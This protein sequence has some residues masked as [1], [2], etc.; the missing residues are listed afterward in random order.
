MG[1]GDDSEGEDDE[2]WK[3]RSPSPAIAAIPETAEVRFDGACR[4][5]TTMV[6]RLPWAVCRK[7]FMTEFY[8]NLL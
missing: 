2:H 3:R 8:C 5:A 7:I 1:R 6:D 4:D